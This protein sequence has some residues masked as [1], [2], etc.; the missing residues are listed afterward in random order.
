MATSRRGFLKGCCAAVSGAIASPALMPSFSFAQ[1]GPSELLNLIDIFLPGGPD[2]RYLYPY[3][4]GAVDV[5]LRARRPNLSVNQSLII[6]PTG[7]DQNGRQNPIGFHP[8]FAPFVNKINSTGAGVALITEFGAT[9]NASRSHEVAQ[10]MYR[11]ASLA[12]SASVPSGWI[13][14]TVSEFGL[15]GLSVWGFGVGDPKFMAVDGPDKPF[16]VSSLGSVS[17]NNR[18][19]SQMNCSGLNPNPCGT[20]SATAKED[21]IYMRDVLKRLQDASGSQ[22]SSLQQLLADSQ[23]SVFSA[24]PVATRMVSAVTIDM[25]EFGGGNSSTN[26]LG[27]ACADIARALHYLNLSPQAPASIKVGTK[28]FATARGGWDSHSNQSGTIPG[29]ISQVANSI[30]GLVHYL[31]QWDLLDRTVIIAHGEFGR[32]SAQNSSVGTDHAEAGH[33][34]VVGG[35]TVVRRGVFGPEA[36]LAQAQNENFFTAQVP[37]TGILR[38]I[39]SKAFDPEGLDRVFANPMPGSVPNFLV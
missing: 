34:L 2:S 24:V 11:D 3:L 18:D 19:F 22:T 5:V 28:L 25:N 37:Q 15:P 13:G 4:S 9:A 7:F 35:S 17:F 21:S 26:P 23:R 8:S 33:F 1:G 20:R 32:T 30:A 12:G 29:N 38:A 10:Q 27:F 6:T 39:L 36:S 14:R 16:V 31:D